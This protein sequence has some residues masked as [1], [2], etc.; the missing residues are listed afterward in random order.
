MQIKLNKMIMEVIQQRSLDY[1]EAKMFFASKRLEQRK[2][3]IEGVITSLVPTD[4]LIK[5]LSSDKLDLDTLLYI[6]EAVEN[7]IKKTQNNTCVC[8]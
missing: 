6:K 2:L 7:D 4:D 5:Q 3:E 8:R 1:L